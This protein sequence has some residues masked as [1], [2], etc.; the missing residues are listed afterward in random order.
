M[1]VEYFTWY[2]HYSALGQVDP[3]YTEYV[4]LVFS[5]EKQD[6]SLN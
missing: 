1:V 5:V 6:F 2:N 3:E 4:M